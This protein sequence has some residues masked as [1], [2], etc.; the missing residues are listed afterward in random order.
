M[1]A[2]V[3]RCGR[4]GR[5]MPT[6][7]R[8]DRARAG[9]ADR[10]VQPS[11]QPGLWR[12]PCPAVGRG[13]RPVVRRLARLEVTQSRKYLP[14]ARDYLAASL[15]RRVG[16]RITETTM[17]D[18]RDWRPDIGELGKLHV[19]YGKGSHGRGHKTRLV[20]AIDGADALL[21]WWL[22]DV[23]HQFGEDWADPD[24]PPLPSER[25][26]RDT[27]RRTRAGGREHAAFGFR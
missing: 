3:V 20:P 16:L 11:N 8:Y 15:W 14:A 19:R 27:G 24:A 18:I 21:T 17:L 23:R 9:P 4:R 25:R 2:A 5:R 22:T 12:E 6:H 10:R 13:S 1:F 7:P 26:D